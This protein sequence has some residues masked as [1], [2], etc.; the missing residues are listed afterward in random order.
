MKPQTAIAAWQ[1]EAINAIACLM[2][3]P[4]AMYIGIQI[5]RIIN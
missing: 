4:V 2:L 5:A 3:L 1:N